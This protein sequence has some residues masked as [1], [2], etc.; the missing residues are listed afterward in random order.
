MESISW[1]AKE[2]EWVLTHLGV[3]Q[4]LGL[5][6]DEVSKREKIFGKNELIQKPLRPLYKVFLG[7]FASPLIYLLII[8]AIAAAL[9][10]EVKDSIVII[11]VVLLNSIIGTIQEGRAERSLAAL[12]KITSVLASVLRDGKMIKIPST[13]LVPGDII[14]LAAGDSIPADSRLIDSFSF[15]ISEAALTGESLPVPKT[16]K[17]LATNTFI[18]DRYNMVYAGT[19][20]TSGRAK[21]VVV[22]TGL[23]TEIGQISKLAE[24]AEIL[25]TPLEKRIAIFSRYLIVAAVFLLIIILFAGWVD[26]IPWVEIILIGISQVVSMVPE[27]LPVAMT[28]ALAVGVQRMAAKKTIVRKLSAVETLGS[29][30]VICSDKTGTLTKNEMTVTKIKLGSGRNFSIEGVGYFPEGSILEKGEKIFPDENDDLGILIKM[31]VLCNDSDLTFQ[32]G[33]WKAIGD[34]T[35]AA[36]IVMGKKSGFLKSKLEKENPRVAEIPFNSINKIMVT[37]HLSQDGKKFMALKGALEVILPLCSHFSDQGEKKHLD[38]ERIKKIHLWGNQLAHEALRVLAMAYIPGKALGSDNIDN[39]KN[40]AVFLGLIGQIDPPRE[41]VAEAIKNCKS[42]GIRPIMITGDHKIT[43]LEIAKTIGL[44]KK[45]DIAMDGEELEKLSPEEIR[46]KLKHV[47]VFAR[48]HPSQKLKIVEAF[49]KNHEV[50]AVTGDGVNDAPALTKADV[51]VAMGITGTEVAKEASK[52]IITDDNFSTIVSAIAQGRLVY[53]NIKKTI[54]LFFSTSAAEVVVLLGALFMGFPPPFAAVQI[55]WNNLVTE[56]LITVNLIMDPMEGDELKRPP[57]PPNEPLV[58]RMMFKRIILMTTTISIVTLGWFIYRL[59][60]GI[61]FAQ[62]R[63]ETFTLL[64]ICEWYNVLNCRSE[65][66]TAFSLSIFKNKWLIFGLITGA[67]LQGAVVYWKPLSTLF[68]T[69]PLDLVEI[70][71]LGLVAL[72]VLLV[73]ELRKLIARKHKEIS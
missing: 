56:G 58:T 67:L 7:Q 46:K 54:L 48:V 57:T 49:Q 51:G 39:L 55:L 40:K 23:E 35:E 61:S 43:G 30:T 62:A 31:A 12:K 73:E 13:D 38:E 3:D 6:F 37:E 70:P 18:A 63:T 16:K 8:A 10:G 28:V 4:N 34:P 53:Q 19:F 52:I 2:C 29:T 71:M 68:Y 27:G 9:L 66:K 72:P 44:A 45:D 41:E 32:D 5:T 26:K 50:V 21:A 24:S 11:F 65:L 1:H 22:A 42:A 60:T 14:L 64:A 15:E 33:T 47:S 59:K 69:V 36:L 17:V 25:A 20:V